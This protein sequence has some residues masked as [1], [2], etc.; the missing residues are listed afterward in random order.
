MYW[1]FSKTLA[2]PQFKFL[3]TQPEQEFDE[4]AAPPIDDVQIMQWKLQTQYQEQKK[5]QYEEVVLKRGVAGRW[6]ILDTFAEGFQTC[7]LFD[8]TKT[9]DLTFEQTKS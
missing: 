6:T 9:K 4:E 8:Q 5:K 7:C 3:Q 2:P 1:E